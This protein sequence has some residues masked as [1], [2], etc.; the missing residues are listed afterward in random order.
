MTR[1][2]D[3]WRASCQCWWC[4]YRT[5]TRD[6]LLKDGRCSR[7]V[8]DFLSSSMHPYWIMAILFTMG[9]DMSDILCVR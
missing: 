6:H 3:R 1:L 2:I 8:L 7:A 4:G 5:Q 9:E